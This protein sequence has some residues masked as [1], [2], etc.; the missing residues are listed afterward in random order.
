METSVPNRCPVSTDIR[1]KGQES[2][3]AVEREELSGPGLDVKEPGR[4]CKQRSPRRTSGP[5]WHVSEGCVNCAIASEADFDRWLAA[6]LEVER[7]RLLRRRSRA[8]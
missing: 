1:A 7:T 4:R 5:N 2:A 6:K 8:A 3:A